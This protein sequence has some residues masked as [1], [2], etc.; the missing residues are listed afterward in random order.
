MILRR[1]RN[2]L[3]LKAEFVGFFL[4]RLIIFL[5]SGVFERDVCEPEVRDCFIR[6]RDE[7]SPNKRKTF[8]PKTLVPTNIGSDEMD[9]LRTT[10]IF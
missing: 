3:F 7:S 6:R 5:R 8:C 9:E 2:H 1:L 4:N 10:I